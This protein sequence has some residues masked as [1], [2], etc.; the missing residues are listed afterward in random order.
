VQPTL[1]IASPQTRD[2]FFQNTVV[3]VWQHDEDGALGV[4]INRSLEHKLPD[5]LDVKDPVDLS[6]YADT[7]VAWGGPVETASG[8][9]IT[10]GHI[11]EEEGW[12][13]PNGVGITRSQDA[14]L[15][16]LGDR[17]P[18]MLCLGY[19]GWGPGQLVREIE[20]GGWLWTDCDARLIFDTPV[21]QRYDVALATLG[22]NASSLWMRPIEE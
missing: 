21:D 7:P 6:A 22:L 11:T 14:L 13:L 9:V 16:L 20:Q 15:R 1:L 19:A 17:A 8:T 5:I 12:V 10:G 18:L 4:V 2:P 3:L